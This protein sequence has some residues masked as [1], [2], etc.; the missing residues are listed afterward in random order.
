MPRQQA[1]RRAA[2][3]CTTV[4]VKTDEPSCAY[5]RRLC[6]TI[7]SAQQHAH[8]MFHAFLQ[9]NGLHILTSSPLASPP[10]PP[11]PWWCHALFMFSAAGR[12]PCLS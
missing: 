7:S 4:A 5:K 8:F 12:R 10:L 3:T 1:G 11:S 6:A 9:M 2:A